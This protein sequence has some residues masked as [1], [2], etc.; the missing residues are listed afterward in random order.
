MS[1]NEAIRLFLAALRERG[2]TRFTYDPNAF[3]RLVQTLPDNSVAQVF[4]VH[5]GVA[6]KDSLDY[7]DALTQAFFSCL[8]YFRAP[9]YN[10]VEIL[11]SSWLV[12]V[13]L[14]GEHADAARQLAEKFMQG[15]P[16]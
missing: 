7:R 11:F 2:V 1:P 4:H 16:P 6:G 9:T 8:C 5:D 14:K 10:E 13:Y 3:A 12:R 15:P